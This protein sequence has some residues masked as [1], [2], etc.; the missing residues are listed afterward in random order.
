MFKITGNVNLGVIKDYVQTEKEAPFEIA[1]K[2]LYPDTLTLNST[3]LTINTK[4]LSDCFENNSLPK[5]LDTAI[6]VKYPIE[7]SDEPYRGQIEK[8]VSDISIDCDTSEFIYTGDWTKNGIK[9]FNSADPQRFVIFTNQGMVASINEV[10]ELSVFGTDLGGEISGTATFTGRNIEFAIVVDGHLDNA[11]YNVKYD[12]KANMSFSL[13]RNSYVGN[14]Y[15]IEIE[16]G[17]KK[18]TYN[19]GATGNIMPE[20]GFK[21]YEEDRG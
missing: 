12:G 7:I 19:A 6:T 20:N 5:P 17:D 3:G 1:A 14:S 21:T 8:I 13:P 15:A 10:D 4:D 2:G 11:F 16:Y 9:V 18:L